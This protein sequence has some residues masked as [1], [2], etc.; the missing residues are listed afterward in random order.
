MLPK[1]HIEQHVPNTKGSVFWVVVLPKAIT[2]NDKVHG[3]NDGVEGSDV[4]T[5]GMGKKEQQA[6][7]RKACRTIMAKACKMA[8]K[9]KNKGLK[10]FLVTCDSS[11]KPKPPI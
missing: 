4:L 11:Q 5:I 6:M 1:Q 3:L 10:T 8:I 9:K 2:P 7:Q